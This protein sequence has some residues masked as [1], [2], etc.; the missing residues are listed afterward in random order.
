MYKPHFEYFYLNDHFISNTKYIKIKTR[1]LKKDIERGVKFLSEWSYCEKWGATPSSLRFLNALKKHI[2][3]KSAIKAELVYS[4]KK[5]WTLYIYTNEGYT[6]LFK[7][8]SGGYYG[9]GTRG[10]YDILKACGFNERQ[11]Q[12]TWKNGTFKVLKNMH[13]IIQDKMSIN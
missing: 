9:Q 12:K 5:H 2:N 10:C 7:G 13:T 1:T 4:Q 11:C 6:L 8:V 3:V